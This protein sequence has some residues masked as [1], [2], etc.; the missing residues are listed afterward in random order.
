MKY[1]KQREIILRA[2]EMNVIHPTADE[3]YKDLGI[4]K[5]DLDNCGDVDIE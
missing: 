4:T 5:E 1:S 3:L 2:L